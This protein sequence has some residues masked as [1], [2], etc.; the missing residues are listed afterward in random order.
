MQIVFQNPFASLNPRKTIKSTL[1]E[2]LLLHDLVDEKR[3]AKEKAFEFLNTVGLKR[4]HLWR[5]PHELSGGQRQ[6]VCIARAL[7]LEPSFVVLDEPTSSLDVSV[8]AQVLDLMKNLKE[9][10]NL[11][12]LFIS[13][14][15]AVVNYMSEIISVMYVGKISL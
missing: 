13:H 5:Y 12:Y 1:M 4:E 14:N 10:F 7:L 11:T 2:G 3:E 8:Q 15:I 9:K 6:R